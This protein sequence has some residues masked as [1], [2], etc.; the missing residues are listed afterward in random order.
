MARLYLERAAMIAPFDSDVTAQLDIVRRIVR[1]RAIE[2]SRTGKTLDGDEPLFWWRLGSTMWPPAVAGA[3]LLGL[4][5]A[6]VAGLLRRFHRH[7]AV[8]DAAFVLL[9]GG[10]LLAAI[11]ITASGLRSIAL[12]QVQP[13]V[14]LIADPVVRD[15]PSEH[16]RKMGVPESA[17]PGTVVR[18]VEERGDWTKIALPGELEGWTTRDAVEPIE[19]RP[20]EQ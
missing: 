18:I 8:R 11:G 15:G 10:G 16:A 4:W 5:L 12:S 17:I 20:S 6:L 7:A 3:I 1:L 19:R 13:A 9:I 14:L 2:S